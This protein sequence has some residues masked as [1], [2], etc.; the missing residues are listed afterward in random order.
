M[1]DHPDARNTLA[2]VPQRQGAPDRRHRADRRTT[3]KTRCAT[4]ACRCSR[5]T[6]SSRSPRRSSIAS[7]RRRSARRSSCAPRPATARCRRRPSSTS[8][9]ICQDELIEL[10]GPVD[11]DLDW[12]KK[13]PTAIMMV[14]LQGSGKTTTVGKL[15]RW[16]EKQQEAADAGGGR[17]LSSGRRRAAQGA[18]RAARHAGVHDRGRHRRPRSAKRRSSARYETN[19]DVVHLRHRRPPGDRR[20]AHGRSSTRSRSGRSRTRSSS[21]STR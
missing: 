16:L 9:S 13:G 1:L 11:T 7:R 14:G 5:P 20:A 3:S 18:R 12:A 2:R 6:S 8:S 10:M 21:S 19:R 4:C 17:H 15:A